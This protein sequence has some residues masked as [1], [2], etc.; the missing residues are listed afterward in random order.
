MVLSPAPSLGGRESG[1]CFIML[2]LGNLKQT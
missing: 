1:D 2:T